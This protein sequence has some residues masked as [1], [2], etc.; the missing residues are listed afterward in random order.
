MNRDEWTT[1]KTIGYTYDV[2]ND[3]ASQGGTHEHQVRLGPAGWQHRIRQS[4]GEHAATG[5]VTPLSHAEGEAHFATAE[6]L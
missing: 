2:A 3:P 4:N 5:P 6:G 1:Y